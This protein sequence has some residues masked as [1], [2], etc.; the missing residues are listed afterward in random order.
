M[1]SL[2]R[3]ATL[4]VA[5]GSISI[6]PEEISWQFARSGGPGGQ[7]VN[8]TSSKATL[9]FDARRSTS[10]PDDVRARLLAQAGS[11]LT[12]RGE[13]VI[14]SQRHREQPRNVSDCLEKLAS[15]LE[16]AAVKP[17]RRRKTRTPRAAVA[18]RLAEKRHRA[19]KK[20]SRSGPVE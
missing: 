19:T 1:T 14:S 15:L 7:H 12:R 3:E 16:R 17:K 11:L 13:L 4:R 20:Q 8:R 5:N 9:R 6:A 18:K 2:G 10:L